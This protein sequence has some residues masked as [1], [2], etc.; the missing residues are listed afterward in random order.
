MCVCVCG[1][2][3]VSL[4]GKKKRGCIVR[5]IVLHTCIC[6]HVCSLCCLG[7]MLI[8]GQRGRLSAGLWPL[9]SDSRQ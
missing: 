1:D 2:A 8:G 7:H 6:E 4:F 9:R 5:M 3:C